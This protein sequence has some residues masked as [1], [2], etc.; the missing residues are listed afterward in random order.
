MFEEIQFRWTAGGPA[1]QSPGMTA[2][3]FTQTESQRRAPPNGGSPLRLMAYGFLYWALI[4]TALEPGN[5]ANMALQGDPLYWDDELLRILGAGAIGSAS[6][7]LCVHLSRRFP[8]A[9]PKLTRNVMIHLGSAIC[10]GAILIIVAHLVATMILGHGQGLTLA[11]T[12]NDLAANELLLVVGL[13]G[14]SGLAH[15]TLSRPLTPL[16]GLVQRRVSP[17]P[18]DAVA[19]TASDM[20]EVKVRGVTKVVEL[21]QVD[22]IE[23]Q[24]NYLALHVGSSAYLLRDTLANFQTRLNPARFARIHRRTIVAIDR[25]TGIEPAANGDGIV[26]LKDG[27]T[28]RASRQYRRQLTI[29]KPV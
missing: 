1:Q 27:Q 21:G 20:I 12:L 10:V 13:V 2:S 11:G 26:R 9:R 19:V 18:A 22:W 5:L 6:A 29:R 4:V 17:A 3:S 24:G 16:R 25:I 28:L 8:V 15:L 7:P 23:A 14:L